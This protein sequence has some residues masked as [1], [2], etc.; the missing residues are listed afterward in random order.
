MPIAVV[1]QE[2]VVGPD[3]LLLPGSQQLLLWIGGLLAVAA[4]VVL[5][6]SL[7][8][9][10]RRRRRALPSRRPTV[11]VLS[12][13]ALAVA[14]ALLAVNWPPAFR[15]P[16]MQA[17]PRLFPAEAFFYREVGG[18]A[19]GASSAR[20]VVALGS[21]PLNV[22]ACGEVP[23]GGACGMPY[24]VVDGRTPRSPV[25]VA[26]PSGPRVE[27]I[28]IADPPWI[29]GV[30]TYPYD[31]HYVAMDPTAGRMWETWGMRCWFGRWRADSSAQWDL[32]DLRF[33]S[34][35]TTASGLPLFPMVFTWGEV[36]SGRIDHVLRAVSPVVGAAHVW[37]ARDSDGPSED[38]DAPPMGAWLRLRDDVELGD[39]GPQASVIAEALRRHGM[40]L[41]DTGGSFSV[42]GAVDARW[43]DDDLAGLGVLTSDDFEVVDASALMVEPDS[44]A[45]APIG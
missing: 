34:G 8:R 26:G 39:L 24:N 30:P 41:A 21:M 29:Q 38:P 31:L 3:E 11:P 42:M 43:D 35:T 12:G 9:R 23:P 44:M 4:A 32:T 36:A 6:V 2:T 28:P 25:R 1:A 18:L 17:L 13:V 5:G 15:L 37:P 27:Q 14:A 10:H 20:I 45:S 16:E 7:W 40:V 22:D 19:L 33:P